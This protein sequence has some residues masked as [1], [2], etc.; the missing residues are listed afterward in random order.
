MG[1]FLGWK[2]WI[3]GILALLAITAYYYF[4]ATEYLYLERNEAKNRPE[5]W[6]VPQSL[7]LEKHVRINGKQI[8]F[9]GITFST[10]WGDAKLARDLNRGGLL[11]FG[12]SRSV[13]F[14]RI[15]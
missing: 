6:Q 11:T 7:L 10:S 14:F 15:A 5:M 13:L 8:S 9:R 12:E 4:P 3:Y 2:G 1:R